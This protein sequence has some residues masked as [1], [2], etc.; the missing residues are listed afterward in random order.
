MHF[1]H[2]FVGQAG[3]NS[4]IGNF[5]ETAISHRPETMKT[6]DGP[7]LDSPQD[8]PIKIAAVHVVDNHEW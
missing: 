4:S 2:V 7:A 3:R 6:D 1:R 8:L 5:S